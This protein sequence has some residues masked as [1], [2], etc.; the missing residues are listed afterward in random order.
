MDSAGLMTP[1]DGPYQFALLPQFW[2]CI[3]EKAEAGI[4]ACSSFV[5]D[6][7]LDAYDDDPLR[8]WATARPGPPLFVEPSEE[9]QTCVVEVN[10]YV[11]AHYAP[12]W[13]ADFLAGADPWLIAHAM[14]DG[15]R[16]VTF[17]TM[18]EANFTRPKIP[19]VCRALGVATPIN[20]YQMLVELNVNFGVR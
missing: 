18:R 13:A 3:E 4:I 6:E 9:V 17:E 16:V 10:D 12:A 5:Y 11:N 20:T 19:N 7:I 2:E 1:K 15:A 14:V 8:V